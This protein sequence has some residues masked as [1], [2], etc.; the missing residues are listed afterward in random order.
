M[1]T[2]TSITEEVVRPESGGLLCTFA[3]S[4]PTDPPDAP[5]ASSVA[6][7]RPASKIRVDRELI[8]DLAARGAT[9]ALFSWLAYG[10]GSDVIAT[11]RLSG[12]F[13]L[14]N[15]LL[16]VVLVLT[17]R[18]SSEVDRS[19]LARGAT[20]IGTLGPLLARP[21][22]RGV[23]PAEPLVLPLAF[24]GLAI[25]LAGKMSLGRSFGTLPA[26]RGVV[27]SGMYRLV[28]HPIYLGYLFIHL[29]FLLSNA[30]LWNLLVLVAADGALFVRAI[31]EEAVLVK[32][33]HYSD[34]R[35]L[36]RW[37]IVP[38]VF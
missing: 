15:E 19:S 26:N 6:I 33:R 28:R 7:P 32:D 34:Y 38:G 18:F 22:P 30:S 36:V 10:V 1:P 14:F 27:V 37:R 17:R 2:Q 24:V 35:Q 5:S 8:A 31:T 9:A 12:L 13:Y 16:V 4:D 20:L 25:V 21:D 3:P 29:S 23:L 11:G